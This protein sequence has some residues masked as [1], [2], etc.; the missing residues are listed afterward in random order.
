MNHPQ[1][2]G[3]TLYI[4][5][6][7]SRDILVVDGYFILDFILDHL[8]NEPE[9]NLTNITSYINS[10]FENKCIIFTTS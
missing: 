3:G 1:Y 4:S 9:E 8:E 7:F 2:Y 6:E 5:L 10:I